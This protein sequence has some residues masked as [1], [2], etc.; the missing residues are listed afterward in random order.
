MGV[1]PRQIATFV[2]GLC[3]AALFTATPALAAGPQ[4]NIGPVSDIS[5]SCSGQNA[6]VEQNWGDRVFI[7]VGLDGAVYVTWD[8]GP[9]RKTVTYL[10]DPSGSCGFATGQLNVV[11]QKSTDRGKS[12]G[13]MTYVSPGF[14]ASGGDS[15]PM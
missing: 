9:S 2:L 5:A 6:E 8:Y 1:N 12:F 10:C 11:M 13:P 14:P 3:A 15:A 4:Y 7:A